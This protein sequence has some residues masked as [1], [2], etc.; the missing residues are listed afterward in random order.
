MGASKPI[1]RR[2]ARIAGLPIL[3]VLVWVD[4]GLPIVYHGH[5]N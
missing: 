2:V 3:E 5:D 4:C 1:F